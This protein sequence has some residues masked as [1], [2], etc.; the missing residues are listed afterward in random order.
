MCSLSSKNLA[1]LE[2]ALNYMLMEE[3]KEICESLNI[4]CSG[5]KGELIK[6]IL[7]F[8]ISG[9]ILTPKGIPATSKAKKGEIYPLTF[10]TLI[11]SGSYKNDLNTRLFM[12]KLVGKH[13]HFTAFGQ[14]WI[15]EQ[16]LAGTPPTYKEF[17]IFWQ[18]EYEAR[19]KKTANPK[20]EWAYLNFIQSYLVKTPN[21]PRNEITDA[22]EKERRGQAKK[23]KSLLKKLLEG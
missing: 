17:A 21:A 13:F 1:E 6:R 2:E 15:K 7:H 5:K 4:P 11:L 16:W 23:A 10:N 22:W 12:Q 8:V 9:K 3:L 20:K 18:R 14:D 19:K